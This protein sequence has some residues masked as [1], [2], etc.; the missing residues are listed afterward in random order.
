MAHPARGELLGGRARDWLSHEPLGRFDFEPRRAGFVNRTVDARSPRFGRPF[1]GIVRVVSL[2][3]VHLAPA[4]SPRFGR[5]W[6]VA[7]VTGFSRAMGARFDFEQRQAGFVNRIA[8][9][10]SP[11]FGRTFV[12]IARVVSLGVVHLAPAASP[13][14]G[15]SWAVE[16][17]M[18]DA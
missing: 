11:R 15:R 3:V 6:A 4:A 13:R 18:R 14:F 7:R 5:C 8:D 1:V 16:C 17:V 12:S 9:E 2:G 10:R